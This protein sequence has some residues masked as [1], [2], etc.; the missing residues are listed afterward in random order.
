VTHDLAEAAFFGEID[1]PVLV[2]TQLARRRRTSDG[3]LDFSVRS[4]ARRH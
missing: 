1:P 2:S 4:L 3:I